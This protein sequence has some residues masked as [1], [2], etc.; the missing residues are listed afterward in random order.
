MRFAYD[1]HF[2]SRSE[3]IAE[4][5]DSEFCEDPVNEEQDRQ[6]GNNEVVSQDDIQIQII[7]HISSFLR[8]DNSWKDSHELDQI[9]MYLEEAD[10]NEKP[11]GLSIIL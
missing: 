11:E 3:N 10:L 6:V 4:S 8:G 9:V 7:R 5:R 2:V 1:R